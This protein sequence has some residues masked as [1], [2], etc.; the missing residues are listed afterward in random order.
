MRYSLKI[1]SK[2]H[3]IDCDNVRNLYNLVSAILPEMQSYSNFRYSI[4]PMAIGTDI[5][6]C[7]N[8]VIR[9]PI[10]DALL[11]ERAKINSSAQHYIRVSPFFDKFQDATDYFHDMCSEFQTHTGIKLLISDSQTKSVKRNTTRKPIER[12]S[13]DD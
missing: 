10:V 11:F 2:T 4:A 8:M 5:K 3:Y 7:V 13:T 12:F 6:F 1:N 9:E